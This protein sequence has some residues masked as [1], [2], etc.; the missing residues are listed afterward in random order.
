M[1]TLE[2]AFGGT[3]ASLSGQPVKRCNA[4]CKYKCTKEFPSRVRDYGTRP[5]SYCKVCD[6]IVERCRR[7]RGLNAPTVRAA[8]QDGSIDIILAEM[9]E[10]TTG[11]K[12]KEQSEEPPEKD[13]VA[14]APFKTVP[15]VRG[16]L[17]GGSKQCAICKEHKNLQT[18]K[19][20]GRQC[21]F[22]CNSPDIFCTSCRYDTFLTCLY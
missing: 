3:D 8:M 13:S 20:D 14:P 16:A 19:S 10:E 9:A 17:V 1:A 7:E 11:K 5:G 22:F 12:Q 2:P 15:A 4:C 6:P 21:R 18:F